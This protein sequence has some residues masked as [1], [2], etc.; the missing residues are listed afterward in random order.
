MRFTV[1]FAASPEQAETVWSATRDF[2]REQGMQTATERYARIVFR[3]NGKAYDLKVGDIHPD[4]NEPV[5]V[6]LKSTSRPLYY[7][8]TPNRG[9]VRGDPYLVGVEGTRALEFVPDAADG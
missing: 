3:H 2:L 6:I 1:P 7:V 4:L 5:L 9:V 8:C